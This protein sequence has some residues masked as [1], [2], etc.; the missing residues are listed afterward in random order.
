MTL[1][2]LTGKVAVVTGAGSGLG[3]QTA[4]RLAQQGADLF[5]HYRT[6]RPRMA[7]A[8][9]EMRQSGRQVEAL[10]ADFAADPGLAAQVVQ[11]A[12]ARFGKVDILVNNAA[13]VLKR[14]VLE[15][16]PRDL[17]EEYLA[18]NVTSVFLALQAA[19][20]HMIERGA[21][22]RII[23]LSSI[24]SRVTTEDFVGYAAAKGAINSLTY[25]AAVRLGK[26]GITV[27]AVAP[28]AIQVERSA[29]HTDAELAS[30]FRRIPMGRMGR[31]DDI[32][33]LITFLAS[34]EASYIT[35]EVI[36]VDG[37]VT[38]RFTNLQP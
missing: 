21:G 36:T 5:L 32:A 33:S 15:D 2:D 11:S 30:W 37:G 7:E 18:V 23:N 35:G 17:F 19:A 12:I 6:K 9:A 24:L 10:S 28:G 20:R 14:E 25:S 13:V 8:M 27:N 22:G 31:A 38:R 1:A 16:Y 4:V 34:D 26:H 3:L 29:R